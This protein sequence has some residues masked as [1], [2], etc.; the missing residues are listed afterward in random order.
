ML[1]A[2]WM[3]ENFIETV[4]K[5]QRDGVSQR[6]LHQFQASCEEDRV[7]TLLWQ[8]TNEK[9]VWAWNAQN[10]SLQH[11]KLVGV[12][13]HTNRQLSV[14]TQESEFNSNELGGVVIQTN[15][16][17]WSAKKELII[18]GWII[19]HKLD[20]KN[21]NWLGEDPNLVHHG[22]QEAAIWF[23][24]VQSPSYLHKEGYWTRICH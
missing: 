12:F 3:K 4:T 2:C 10:T 18:E 5:F 23:S 8:M 15:R 6:Q 20:N 16:Y 21:Y 13:V 14:P 9:H 19:N 11:P 17:C 1:V 22:N 7:L 24:L